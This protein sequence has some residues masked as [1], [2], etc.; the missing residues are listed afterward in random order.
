[1]V[2]QPINVE[3]SK[4]LSAL[5]KIHAAI[6]HFH[7]GEFECAMTLAAAAEGQVPD[8]DKPYLFRILK[9]VPDLDLNAII[10]WLKHDRAQEKA[11]ISEFEVVLTISR[12][13][14]KFVAAYR[15]SSREFEDFNKWAVENGHMPRPLTEISK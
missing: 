2:R 5:R 6:V 1:V 12:A 4:K 13:I 15:K 14:H 9:H 7:K 10:N 11:T 8:S 3:T